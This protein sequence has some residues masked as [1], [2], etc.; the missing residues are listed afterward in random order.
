[1]LSLLS[2]KYLP[3]SLHLYGTNQIKLLS[4]VVN[5]DGVPM[6]LDIFD[7]ASQFNKAI[8]RSY[9]K[10]S[11]CS[12]L[13]YDITRRETFKSIRTWL[14][15]ARQHLGQHTEILLIGNKCDMEKIRAVSY[16]EGEDFAKK[17]G[18]MFM[19]TSVK[20]DYN[21]EKALRTMHHL[22]KHASEGTL[23]SLARMLSDGIHTDITI[24]TGDGSIGAHRAVLASRSP[25]F[26]NMF[27]HNLKEKELSTV[28]ISDMSIDE[29]RAMLGFIYADLSPQEFLNHR[30]ALIR[31]ANKY[32]ISDIKEACVK[33]LMEDIDSGNVFELLETAQLYNLSGLKDQCIQFL[34]KSDAIHDDQLNAFIQSADREFIED[35][36]RNILAIKRR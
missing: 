4:T 15:D 21:V 26:E 20:D 28:E 6:G 33:S 16:S 14:E 1:M 32:D 24:N 30:L 29:L 11:T 31:A 5:M 2:D 18:L 10:W 7:V 25:V 8:T 9:L 12:M 27:S 35:V 3:N 17:N 36:F 13:I 19:E 23:S 22:E 34:V